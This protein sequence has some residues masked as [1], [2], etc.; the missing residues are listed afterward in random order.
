VPARG[1]SFRMLLSDSL[2]I[3]GAGVMVVIPDV[4]AT[5]MIL[6]GALFQLTCK[7]PLLESPLSRQ[8]RLL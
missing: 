2:W 7:P 6:N 4:Y 8:L 1:I 3:V 5:G